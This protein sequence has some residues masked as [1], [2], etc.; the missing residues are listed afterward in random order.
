MIFILNYTDIY[1]GPCVFVCFYINEKG[2]VSHTS[3]RC[4][5]DLGFI[6]AR[7]GLKMKCKVSENVKFVK[8]NSEAV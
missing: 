1:L 5:K 2:T 8:M 4:P 7:G 3:P 6:K